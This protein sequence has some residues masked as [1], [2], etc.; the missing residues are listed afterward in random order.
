MTWLPTFQLLKKKHNF[1]Q[2]L[3]NIRISAHK[4]EIKNGIYN[5]ITRE[6]RIC[7]LCS[8]EVEDELHFQITCQKLS[9]R[10]KN[11]EQNIKHPIPE[12]KSLNNLTK[13][14]I[15]IKP[16]I[17]IAV[18]SAQFCYELLHNKNKCLPR[19]FTSQN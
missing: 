4:L 18:S 13:F 19:A 6:H 5:K 1:R 14:Y 12:W 2:A 3:T 16:P 15:I 17:K 10:R 11:F 8:I 7:K 9:Q